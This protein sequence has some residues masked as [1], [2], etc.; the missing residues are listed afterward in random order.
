MTMP[1]HQQGFDAETAAAR[2]RLI[3]QLQQL[4]KGFQR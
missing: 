2:Q 1:R 3:E 4:A